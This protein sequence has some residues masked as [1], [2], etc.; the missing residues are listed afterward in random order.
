MH[1]RKGDNVIILTGKDKG[2]SGKI[3]NIKAGRVIIE[4]LNIVKRHVRKNQ[5][6]P[7]GA[8][9]DLEAPLDISNVMMLCNKCSK[10]TKTKMKGVE[11]GRK[12]RICKKCGEII[13]KV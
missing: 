9:V 1:L 7:K 4:G 10:P 5:Q 13:D 11:E 8:I 2:K 6:Y 3:M 12:V